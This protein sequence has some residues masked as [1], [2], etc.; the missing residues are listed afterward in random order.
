M[1]PICFYHRVDLD[2]KCSAAIVLRAI[3][4]VELRGYNYGDDFPWGEVQGRDVIMVDC[5]L[6]P[7]EDMMRLSKEAKSLT[8]IDHHKTAIDEAVHAGWG[9]STLKLEVGRAGCELA[10]EYYFPSEDI[11]TAVY[12]LGRYDVWDHS[13]SRTLPFQYGMRQYDQPSPVE[14]FNENCVAPILRDGETILRYQRKQYEM[15]AKSR[16]FETIVLETDIAGTVL[17]R[18]IACNTGLVNSQLFDSVWDPEQ[19]D[20]MLTFQRK[21]KG[22][23][24]VSLYSTKDNVDCGA[25]SKSFGGG[26]H[27]GAAGFQ[28]EDLPFE[29]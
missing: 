22:L 9:G 4:E 20:V 28:C 12:L 24:T 13:D 3:P 15:M 7:F 5:S 26:G 23:W 8:W 17:Y 6:Q 25:I 21:R 29:V 2:G 18:A 27:K 14:F 10:W 19:Y 16:C 1:N 11:P